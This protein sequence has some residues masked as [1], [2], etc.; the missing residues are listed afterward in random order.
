MGCA[1][2]L[3]YQKNEWPETRKA[4]PGGCAFFISCFYIYFIKLEGVK[5]YERGVYFS[6]QMCGLAGMQ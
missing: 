6:L 2:V 4:R 3:P 5:W 1:A